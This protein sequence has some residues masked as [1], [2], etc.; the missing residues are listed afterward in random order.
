MSSRNPEPRRGTAGTAME[1]PTDTITFLLQLGLV[2]D[3]CTVEA[4]TLNLKALKDLAVDFINKKVPALL[5]L[6][7]LGTVGAIARRPRPEPR[8]PRPQAEAEARPPR[9]SSVS[10]RDW[11]AQAQGPGGGCLH[12]A[13][14]GAGRVLRPR[15]RS[16]LGPDRG[17]AVPPVVSTR[18][19]PDP[20]PKAVRNALVWNVMGL[21]WAANGLPASSRAARLDALPRPARMLLCWPPASSR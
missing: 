15:R 19:Q 21:P 2:R 5:L 1:E 11:R 17:G 9:V 18:C 10:V 16:A 6:L 20:R 8:Q 4:G 3:T 13:T 14:Y 12:L 7:E